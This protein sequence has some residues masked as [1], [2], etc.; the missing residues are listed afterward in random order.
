MKLKDTVQLVGRIDF[1]CERVG[2]AAGDQVCGPV[3]WSG[4]TAPFIVPTF[5]DG[6]TVS[7]STRVQF[8]PVSVSQ[9]II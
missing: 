2:C 3:S 1:A 4:S 9:L 6:R 8:P 7:I 5:E